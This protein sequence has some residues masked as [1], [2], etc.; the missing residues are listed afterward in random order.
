MCGHVVLDDNNSEFSPCPRRIS[1]HVMFMYIH[2][3]CSVYSVQIDLSTNSEVCLQGKRP[4]CLEPMVELCNAKAA[5]QEPYKGAVTWLLQL[6]ML[7]D[8]VANIAS[9]SSTKK[10][11]N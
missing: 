6:Q 1:V 7:L 4:H 5:A 9:A 2:H 3:D 11:A 10:G 8:N